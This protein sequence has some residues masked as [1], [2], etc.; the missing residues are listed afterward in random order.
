MFVVFKATIEE[1]MSGSIKEVHVVPVDEFD[2]LIGD[3]MGKGAFIHFQSVEVVSE[4]RAA[5][6]LAGAGDIN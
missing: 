6:I 3:L 4:D 1:S 2:A 5:E